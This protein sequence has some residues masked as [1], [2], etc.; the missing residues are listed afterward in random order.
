MPT[1]TW[2]VPVQATQVVP[3]SSTPLPPHSRQSPSPV[4]GVPDGTSSPGR[5]AVGS[6]ASLTA[7]NG[8]TAKVEVSA[9]SSSSVVYPVQI[10]IGAS[11]KRY[12]VT[13]SY[14]SATAVPTYSVVEVP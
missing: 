11:T 4:P 3:A 13:A 10:A 9:S 7:S 12:T 6:V 8:A 14:A 1:V 2:P 5:P